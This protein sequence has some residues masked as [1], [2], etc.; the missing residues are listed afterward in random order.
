MLD[1]EINILIVVICSFLGLLWGVF[2]AILLSKVKL[3]QGVK[4][5]ESYN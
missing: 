5:G 1:T 2:N 3:I 4:S